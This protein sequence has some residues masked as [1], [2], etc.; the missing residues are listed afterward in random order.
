MFVG[1]PHPLWQRGE[2][3]PNCHPDRS[4]SELAPCARFLRERHA[5]AVAQ[6]Y[7]QIATE[8]DVIALRQFIAQPEAAIRLPLQAAVDEYLA[9]LEEGRTLWR[10]RQTIAA[11]E[12]GTYPYLDRESSRRAATQ[13]PAKHPLGSRCPARAGGRSAC[14]EPKH[15]SNMDRMR[16]SH[17][18]GFTL[19]EVTLSIVVGI[20][21]IAGATL[22]YNQA[23]LGAGN[24]RNKAKVT[25][26]RALV[27]EMMAN[28]G[29]TPSV[30]SVYQAWVSRRPDDYATSPYGGAAGVV[31]GGAISGTQGFGGTDNEGWGTTGYEFIPSRVGCL[32][33]DNYAQSAATN[34]VW[35][36]GIQQYITT[37]T[38]DVRGYDQAGN[39][40]M[41]VQ[42][43]I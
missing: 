17:H 9:D 35:D 13:L 32:I 25:S 18:R 43:G 14:R 23:K 37:R 22:L 27:E 36:Y 8:I 30:A 24:A 28:S 5:E 16:P 2:V 12:S 21:L 10:A 11:V 31:G 20:I 34:S 1:L 19:I 15:Y 39:G 26:L 6:E 4:V 3:S 29:T 7:L 38:Y 40:G 41:F 33:Y 42:G